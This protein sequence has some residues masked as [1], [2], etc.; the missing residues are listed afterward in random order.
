MIKVIK[1]NINAP[2]SKALRNYLKLHFST[3]SLV[4]K[5]CQLETAAQRITAFPFKGICGNTKKKE[6]RT[7][8]CVDS[9][10]VLT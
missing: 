10:I 7:F 3:W 1:T 6:K 4:G 5:S 9:C 2:L 8:F